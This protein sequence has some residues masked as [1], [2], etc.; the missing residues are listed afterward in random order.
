[1]KEKLSSFLLLE[2]F[3][4]ATK[5]GG[6][7]E[8]YLKKETGFVTVLMVYLLKPGVTF[9]GESYHALKNRALELLT[10]NN[11]PEM[12][13]LF[14]I[15][16]ERVG[17]ATEATAGD[18]NAWVMDLAGNTMVIPE[19]RVEDFYGMKGMFLRFLSNPGGAERVLNEVRRELNQEIE[20]QQKIQK[21]NNIKAIPWVSVGIAV[22]CLLMGILSYIY[23][24][25]FVDYFSLDP[26]AIFEKHQWYRLITYMYVHAGLSHYVNN[27]VMLY[28]EGTS[29]ENAFG[30]FRYV[31]LYHLLGMIAGLGS[32]AY[33]VFIG[34][35]VPSIGASGAI[36]AFL[37]VIVYLTI[38]NIRSFRGGALYR[39]LVMVLLAFYSVYEGFRTPGVDNAAHVS[40]MAAGIIAGI[41]WDLILRYKRRTKKNFE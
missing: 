29:L 41:A 20:K 22:L 15:M 27:M 3:V 30:R 26:V 33:K 19:D 13:T 17:E 37:G 16:T 21:K 6:D 11:L 1:M 2:G 7:F 5:D 18:R 28:M 35:D 25:P 36:M 38:R 23:G 39:I 31:L 8:I 12:H 10:G 14:L 34:S 40:G 32:L 24:E 9:T 4:P